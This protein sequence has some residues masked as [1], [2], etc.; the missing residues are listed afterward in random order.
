MKRTE[1]CNVKG[2]GGFIPDYDGCNHEWH[3]EP[4]PSCSYELIRNKVSEA[5]YCRN[6][7]YS[8]PNCGALGKVLS[9]VFDDVYGDRKGR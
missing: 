2:C 8:K 6:C 5:V 1:L 4:C 9:K 7:G 3:G